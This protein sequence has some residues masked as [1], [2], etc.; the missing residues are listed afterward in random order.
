VKET[1]VAEARVVALDKKHIGLELPPFEVV[2][3]HGA[4]QRFAAALAETD[5]IYF[6]EQAARAKGFRSI[7]ALPTFPVVLGTR[8]ELTWDLVA[9]LGVR[10][11]Q[12][13]HGSQRYVLHRTLCA[14]DRLIGCKKVTNLYEKRGGALGFIETTIEYRDSADGTLVCEDFC[15]FVVRP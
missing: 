1:L 4:L 9:T 2:I 10:P 15:T 7:V 14:G 13:L 11:S 12:I 3:E 6:D 8:R 5:P